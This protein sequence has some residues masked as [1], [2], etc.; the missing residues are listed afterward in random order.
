M[1]NYVLGFMF[2]TRGK[3]V[4]LIQKNKPLWQKGLFNGV[5]GKIEPNESAHEAM[6]REFEEET[7][8]HTCYRN[9]RKY[10]KMSG[11]DWGC[12]LF[13]CLADGGELA[14][15]RTVTEEVVKIVK[16]DDV[17]SGIAP[18]I[19]NLPWIITMA[20]DDKYGNGTGR[21]FADVRYQ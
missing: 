16:V 1:I 20:L 6:G 7:G 21:I 3:F 18:V 11:T 17:L 15:V 12:D 8:V 5:G 13:Y 19:S 4:V 9:W 14:D 10:G 2:D